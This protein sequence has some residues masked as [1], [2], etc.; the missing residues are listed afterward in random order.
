MAALA[1]GVAVL[2]ALVVWRD[3]ELSGRSAALPLITIVASGLAVTLLR[4][5]GWRERRY[6]VLGAAL[7]AGLF[8]VGPNIPSHTRTYVLPQRL[9]AT[10]LTGLVLVG[11]WIVWREDLVMDVTIITAQ[12]R[13]E[14]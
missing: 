1:S 10:L 4:R 8:A 5:G 9:L 7:L 14:L 12:D 6:I 13:D 11:A 3:A 2:A